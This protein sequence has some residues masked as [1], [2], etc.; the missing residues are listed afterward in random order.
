MI[1]KP[2]FPPLCLTVC[3]FF[4]AVVFILS[5]L[6]NAQS[7]GPTLQSIVPNSA[8]VGSE[9]V[10][11]TLTGSGFTDSSI[12]VVQG[13]RLEPISRTSTNLVVV[14]P[15]DFFTSSVSLNVYVADSVTLMGSQ[16]VYFYVYSPSPPKITSMIP[17]GGLRGTTTFITLTGTDLTGATFTF[18]GTGVSVV[19]SRVQVEVTVAP[20]APLG[21]QAVTISTPS[22]STNLC[23]LRQCMFTVVENGSWSELSA[24][25]SAQGGTPII[26]TDGR[27]L[28]AGGTSFTPGVGSRALS[29]AQIFDPST[30]QWSATGS[31]NIARAG[32]VGSLLPDGRVLVAGGGDFST[33]LL[34]AEIFDPASG[35]WSLTGS[36][37]ATPSKAL[38]LPNGKVLVQVGQFAA[39]LFAPLTGRFQTLQAIAFQQAGIRDGRM[40]L[41]SDG[42]IFLVARS[43]EIRVYDFATGTLSTLPSRGEADANHDTRLLPDGRVL[44]RGTT[45]GPAPTVSTPHALIFNPQ[46]G[47]VVPAA[48]GISGPDVLLPNGFVLIGGATSRRVGF[49]FE[50]VPVAVLY[51]PVTDRSFPQDPGTAIVL[52]T[53]LLTDGRSF[54][55]GQAYGTSSGRSFT[56]TYGPTPY[57]NPAPVIG[58]VIGSTPTSSAEWISLDIRGTSFLP[59]S[60]VQLGTTKLVTIYLG[61]QRLVA[62]VPPVL[63]PALSAGISVGNPAPAGGT[64]DTVRVG[65][66]VTV[67]LPISEVETGAIRSGY[68]VVTPDAG[69]AA[70]VSTVTYGIV[71]DGL[72]QS[73]AAILP[74]PL[75]TETSIVADIVRAIGRNLGI[76]IANASATPASITVTL[77]DPDGSPASPPASFSIPAR[78]QVARFITELFPTDTIGAAFAGSVT[79]QSSIPVSITGL[80][81][82]GME[83]S[84]VPVPVMGSASIPQQGPIGGANAVMFPQFAMS[85]GWATTLGLV[86]TGA[87]SIS[88]RVDIFDTDGN[89]L[90]V[91]LNGERK[92]TFN[93]A[94]PALGSLILAPRDANGQSPF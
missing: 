94:I 68:V 89:P 54:G 70:P 18:S 4:T 24:Q 92:S 12:V 47:G 27:V 58:S 7:A 5:N 82:S 50:T 93:Y 20:D 39:Q 81:F 22:G 59:N 90:T 17:A 10:T 49:G 37:T 2:G 36:M 75:T 55:M 51:D 73:Q 69:S 78:R 61:A 8:P 65:F 43:G 3:C 33:G 28:V 45:V 38:M 42:R 67:P 85:G 35:T 66:T 48:I 72:V 40:E 1:R 77:R 63:R 6:L 9:A 91:T 34:T 16:L 19:P 25:P 62:F 80:R 88:G 41:L 11:V 44:I 53:L 52:P 13:Q 21:P 60:I 87:T 84:T 15:S 14:I 64:S 46:T 32:A 31:L 56:Q 29:T 74:T 86:N 71:R 79:I 23:G 26:L 30:G 76:A 83:F 57:T